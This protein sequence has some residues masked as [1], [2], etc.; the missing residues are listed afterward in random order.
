MAKSDPQRW[1][2]DIQGNGRLVLKSARGKLAVLLVVCVAFV[3]I[4]VV[5]MGEGGGLMVIGV[6]AVAFFGVLG[7]PVLGWRVAT[8]RPVTVIDH[9]GVAVDRARVGWTEIVGIRVFAAPIKTVLLDTT[10]E[11]EARLAAE[12][13]SW[14]RGLG[15]VNTQLT[16]HTS[17]AL[18]TDQG[19]N[20]DEFASWLRWLHAERTP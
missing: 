1:T 16:G 3:A 15:H 11:A 19:V 14:Q 8:G 4:G 9:S 5:M 18:P 6:L 17:F 12:R 7:L 10:P 13:S 2:A 20:P